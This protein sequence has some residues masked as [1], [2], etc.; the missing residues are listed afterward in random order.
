MVAC[1]VEPI[2][3][4]PSYRCSMGPPS[5]D[6]NIS[7]LRAPPSS[8]RSPAFSKYLAKAIS[9]HAPDLL[10]LA[11]GKAQRHASR[12]GD[13]P[14][15]L[16]IYLHGTDV[17]DNLGNGANGGIH[18]TG[19]VASLFGQAN[20]IMANTRSTVTLVEQSLPRCG[21]NIHAVQYGIDTERLAPLPS[22]QIEAVRERWNL[23]GK[24]VVLCAARLSPKKG[25]D[26]LLKSF[27]AVRKRVPEALLHIA[28]DGPCRDELHNLAHDLALDD[29]VRFLGDLKPDDLS[30]QLQ[31]CD[32]FAMISRRGPSESFGLVYLEANLFGKPV[33]AG[34]TGGVPEAVVDGRTGHLVEP[35]NT[36]ETAN[37]I[38][39]LLQDPDQAAAM[40]EAGRQRVLDEFT[41]VHMARRML[42]LFAANPTRRPSRLRS[43]LW[44]ARKLGQ[45]Y[46]RAAWARLLGAR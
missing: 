6:T 32:V 46:G 20:W 35:H 14:V 43:R 24:K 30:C 12:L 27:A 37:A 26:V 5:R 31:L 11:S 36:R 9:K 41:H 25:Q 16:A 13:F 39:R 34:R 10:L 19:R 23:R 22:G 42:D 44:A 38:C 40:G 15:P 3:L 2:V 1:A 28:G 18:R 45:Y 29:C 17:L 33:V 21:G 4:A 7:V 8:E